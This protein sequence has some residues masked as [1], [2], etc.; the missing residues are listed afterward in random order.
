MTLHQK[1]RQHNCKY[2]IIAAWNPFTNWF[3][4]IVFAEEEIQ[5][6]RYLEWVSKGSKQASRSKKCNILIR[7]FPIVV[8]NLKFK[9]LSLHNQEW[10]PKRKLNNPLISFWLPWQDRRLCI[11]LRWFF[12]YWILLYSLRSTPSSISYTN[13]C[14]T[15]WNRAH[16][17]MWFLWTTPPR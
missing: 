6:P 17:L 3:L 15:I 14:I 7:F 8:H 5:F 1:H 13:V 10:L 12:W 11:L 4:S 2:I 9:F 16:L